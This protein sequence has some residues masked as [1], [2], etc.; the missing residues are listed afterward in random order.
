[1]SEQETETTETQEETPSETKVEPEPA[2]IVTK[3]S[4]VKAG[5]TVRLHE[6]I[7]DVTPKGEV[8][9]RIQIFEGIVLGIK[10]SGISRTLTIRKISAGGFGVERIYPVNSPIIA[11]IE[12][13]K[14]AKVRR[15]KLSFL[16]KI[17]VP[18]KR[19]FKDTYVK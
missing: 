4:E 17:A 9:E 7:K 6:R 15:A 18:F 1:M 16:Q 11:K 8:R 3:S 13:V 5:Q 19:K 2:A 14:T 10:G 12:L